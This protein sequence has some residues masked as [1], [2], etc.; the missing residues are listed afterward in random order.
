MPP[1]PKTSEAQL[2]ASKRYYEK[3]RADP[4][5]M[6]AKCARQNAR[7]AANRASVNAAA[8]DRYRVQTIVNEYARLMERDPAAAEAYMARLESGA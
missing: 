6:A 4:D 1:K 2:A 5:W 8:R 3:K 7:V